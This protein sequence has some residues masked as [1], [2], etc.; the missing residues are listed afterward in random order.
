MSL[1]ASETG[2]EDPLRPTSETF[3]EEDVLNSMLLHLA[4][5]RLG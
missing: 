5:F 1:P 2:V 4:I 3:T